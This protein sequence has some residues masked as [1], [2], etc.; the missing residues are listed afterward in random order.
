MRT[1]PW[2]NAN[3]LTGAGKGNTE[4]QKQIRGNVPRPEKNI[5]GGREV[6]FRKK[7]FE[8]SSSPPGKF[9]YPK[10]VQVTGQPLWWQLAGGG[11]GMD[12]PNNPQFGLWRGGPGASCRASSRRCGSSCGRPR[13]GR[14]RRRGW[15]ACCRRRS[16]CWA[17]CA[18]WRTA[19]T[20]PRQG[21]LH[22]TCSCHWGPSGPHRADLLACLGTGGCWDP[23]ARPW[24]GGD[25]AGAGEGAAAAGGA[26]VAAAAGRAAGGGAAADGGGARGGEP[27]AN[28]RSG[29][30]ALASPMLCLQTWEQISCK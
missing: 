21:R 6:F 14:W 16:S 22:L 11:G 26:G 4:P 18:G 3:C 20:R 2:G 8:L 17:A 24:G 25:G 12:P 7:V 29:P 15:R 30:A 19:C 10:S 27:S 23:P 5:R 9:P 1:K 28:H 13:A